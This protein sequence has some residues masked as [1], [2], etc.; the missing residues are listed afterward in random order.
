MDLIELVV[1]A[2]VFGLNDRDDFSK[3]ISYPKAFSYSDIHFCMPSQS[4]TVALKNMRLSSAK[5]KCDIGGQ[6]VAIRT[7]ENIFRSSMT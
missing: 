7:P 2:F 1:S 5:N 6:D 3:L 4:E